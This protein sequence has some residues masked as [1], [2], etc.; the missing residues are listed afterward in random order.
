MGVNKTSG[1]DIRNNIFYKDND[2]EL[3]RV[4]FT[5]DLARDLT[6]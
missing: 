2:L 6:F 4:R 3:V 1:T 5:E